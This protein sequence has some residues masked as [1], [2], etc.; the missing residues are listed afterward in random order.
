[1]FD[2]A[3]TGGVLWYT[4]PYVEGP[5]LRDALHARRL[6][7]DESCRIACDVG[8][9]LDYAHRRGV[10]H[11]DVKPGNILSTDEQAL[12]ADFG[13]RRSWDRFEIATLRARRLPSA[14][15]PT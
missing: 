5:S 1:V 11:R 14:L 10:V 15:L 7:V 12:L 13:I 3:A 2:S 8:L 9:A 6:D 4:M